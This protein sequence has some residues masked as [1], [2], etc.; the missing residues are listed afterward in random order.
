MLLFFLLSETTLSP[1]VRI[2]YKLGIKHSECKKK[3]QVRQNKRKEYVQL[4]K[5]QIQRNPCC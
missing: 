2:I 4:N 5:L 3:R 1:Y